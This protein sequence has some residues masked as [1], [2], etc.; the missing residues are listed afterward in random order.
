MA[1]VKRAEYSGSRRQPVLTALVA[2]VVVG[3]VIAGV[4]LSW[5]PSNLDPPVD[6]IA[7]ATAELKASNASNFLFYACRTLLP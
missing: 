3:L 6:A 7:E 5:T 4:R 2:G 1:P